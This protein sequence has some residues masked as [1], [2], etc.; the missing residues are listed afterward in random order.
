MLEVLE[1]VKNNLIGLLILLWV[2]PFLFSFGWHFGK[3][4]GEN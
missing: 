1:W 3:S 2:A 4:V